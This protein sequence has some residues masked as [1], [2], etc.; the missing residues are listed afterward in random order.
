MTK[1]NK[2]LNL[3]HQANTIT[4]EILLVKSQACTANECTSSCTFYRTLGHVFVVQ[5]H[6][7]CIFVIRWCQ[8]QARLIFHRFNALI[9][10]LISEPRCREIVPVEWF[11]ITLSLSISRYSIS[12]PSPQCIVQHIAPYYTYIH[13]QTQSIPVSPHLFIARLATH[14]KISHSLSCNLNT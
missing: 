7:I 6:I 9:C 5:Q 8:L 13:P 2:C 1:E 10:P 12:A 4:F 3:K 11:A 14:G